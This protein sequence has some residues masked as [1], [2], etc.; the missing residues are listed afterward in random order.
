MDMAQ[1]KEIDNS[2]N[3][4]KKDQKHDRNFQNLLVLDRTSYPSMQR[5]RRGFRLTPTN[6]AVLKLSVF[7]SG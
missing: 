7:E 3:Q 4:A 2:Q 6:L 5:G 1:R